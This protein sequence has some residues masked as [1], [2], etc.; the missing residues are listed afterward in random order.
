M[1]QRGKYNKFEIRGR[2]WCISTI[3]KELFRNVSSGGNRMALTTY[4]GDE[5]F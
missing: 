1:F 4:P 5:E 2:V 3:M